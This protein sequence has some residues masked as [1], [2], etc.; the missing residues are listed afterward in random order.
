MPGQSSSH[1][2]RDPKHPRRTCLTVPPCC[3]RRNT[4]RAYQFPSRSSQCVYVCGQCVK[5]LL[6]VDCLLLRHALGHLVRARSYWGEVSGGQLGV[7]GDR[8]GFLEEA[9]DVVHRYER[10]GRGGDHN[11]RVHLACTED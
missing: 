10:G 6:G 1:T 2:Q 5:D 9:F 11:D 4:A 8:R 3:P 7:M